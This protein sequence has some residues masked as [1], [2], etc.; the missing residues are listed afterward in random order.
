MMWRYAPH[1]GL[2]LFPVMLLIWGV[3]IAASVMVVR[4]LG[5]PPER[6]DGALDVLRRRLAAGE[7]TPE[8]FETTRKLLQS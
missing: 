7:I 6:R 3:V 5:Q 4:G 2:W 8:E 1:A